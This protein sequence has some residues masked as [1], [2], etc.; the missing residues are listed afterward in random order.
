MIIKEHFDENQLAKFVDP[1]HTCLCN[2]CGRDLGGLVKK[3]TEVE[4]AKQEYQVP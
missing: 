2:H 4:L 3:A 1:N